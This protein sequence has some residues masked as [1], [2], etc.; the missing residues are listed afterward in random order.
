MMNPYVLIVVALFWASTIAGAGYKGF[1]LGKDSA[2]STWQKKWDA[3]LDKERKA[4]DIADGDRKVL[5]N[6]ANQL[7]QQLADA[8]QQRDRYF[9]QLA[10]KTHEDAKKELPSDDH[11]CDLPVSLLDDWNAANSDPRQA[12]GGDTSS[13]SDGKVPVPPESSGT[14]PGAVSPKPH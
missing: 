8:R 7:G 5:Q 9:N 12:E 6:L 11:V 4:I 3:Q 1:E 14:K 10:T 2:N 13:G